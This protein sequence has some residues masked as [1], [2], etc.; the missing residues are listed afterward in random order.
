MRR[1]L[2]VS[3]PFWVLALASPALAEVHS[4]PNGPTVDP[5][6][7]TATRTEKKVSEAP[8][9]V[10]V[11]SADQI[12]D[13]LATDIK[14]LLKF[15]PGVAVR[16]SP[17]RFTVAGSSTG[18]D[19]NSGFNIRGLEG[20]RVLIQVDGIR[21]PDSFSFGAQA[22]GRGGYVDLDL[23]KSMEI[24]RGPASALYGS[25]GV[26]GAVSFITKDPGD[27]LAGDRTFGGQAKV[28]YNSADLS[29]GEGLVATGRVGDW[30]AMI[31][32]TRRDGHEQETKG[33]NGAANTDRTTANPQ[34]ASSNA[35]LA[36]LIFSPTDSQRLRLTYD[37]LDSVLDTNVLSAIAKP[38]LIG[39][40]VLALKTHDTT[41]RDR[42]GLDYRYAAEAGLIQ[43]ADVAAYFQTSRTNQFG[44]EDRNTSADRTR[45]NKFDNRL[46]GVSATLQSRFTTG[47]LSHH[48]V[49]GGDVSTTHQVSLRDGTVPPVGESFPTR[50]FPTTDYT[51]AGLFAQDEIGALGGRLM[52][53]PA[54][55]FDSYKLDPKP[56]A[57]LTTLV[58][59]GQDGSRVSP[60]IGVVFKLTPTVGLFVNAAA[61]FKAP[62]PGQVNNAFA[63][64]VANYKSVPNP[65][66][67]PE[68]SQTVEGGLRLTHAGWSASATAFTGA[69][70][71]FIDQVMIGGSFTPADPAIFKYMNLNRTTISG[72]EAR[73]QVDL[74]GGFGAMGALSYSKGTT[75]ASTGKIPLDSVEPWK[76]VA[77]LTY[78]EAQGRFGGQLTLTH[79]AAKQSDRV[80]SVCAPSCYTPSDFTI[81][82]ATAW[83]APT[84]SATLRMGVFNLTDEKYT[85]WSDVRSLSSASVVT[86]AYTQP[87]RNAGVSLTL[88]R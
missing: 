76:V 22:D 26:A 52:I 71:N 87:G 28:G 55:R 77:G 8:A 4:G 36:K 11:I 88:R 48:F 33:S 60:K 45:I 17:A 70:K 86:D 56:D 31:A 5:V 65:D 84:P 39:S 35:V 3:V 61:G 40:S 82:D 20:N 53:Y 16:S 75:K 59:K 67:R 74:G 78:R 47:A 73:G 9:T 14:D 24:L 81:L 21:V 30:Q 25:D 44:A 58:P 62:A 83:W 13:Q 10:S 34:D 64:L 85:W 41:R 19:G 7:I 38:P 6:T 23:L 68:T 12:D 66:L 46:Y 43:A 29:W 51:L 49:Y 37:H 2:M 15:E 69:Y 54:V 32:Y 1:A 80:G 27:F 79:S 72:F 18:R 63:N 50:A 57:L 42:I